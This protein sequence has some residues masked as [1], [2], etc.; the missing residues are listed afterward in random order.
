[1]D[2]KLSPEEKAYLSLIILSIIF[3]IIA[4]KFLSGAARPPKQMEDIRR[5]KDIPNYMIEEECYMII[6]HDDRLYYLTDSDF[7]MICRCVM[8][9]AGGESMECQEAVATVI[10]NRYFSPKFPN[11]FD[12]ILAPGQFS[13]HYNGKVTDEVMMSVYRA[14]NFYATDSC[15]LPHTCYYFRA[16]HYHNFGIPYTHINNTY[17]SLSEEATD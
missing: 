11:T 10:F 16:G 2:N 13:M 7:E 1:M 14:A 9:E 5:A 4:L 15:L 6:R 8:S 3:M 17:F 12:E